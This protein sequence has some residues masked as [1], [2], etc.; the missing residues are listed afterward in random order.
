MPPTQNHHKIDKSTI[1]S[2]IKFYYC[3]CH[4]IYL[5]TMYFPWLVYRNPSCIETEKCTPFCIIFYGI[6]IN[7]NIGSP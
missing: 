3:I 4:E 5:P 2:R 1:I 7:R 6:D